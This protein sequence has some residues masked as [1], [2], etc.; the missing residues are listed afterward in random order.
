MTEQENR[1]V[2]VREE[3]DVAT[4]DESMRFIGQ[5]IQTMLSPVVEAMAGFM[6]HNTEAVERLAA[7]QKVQTDRIEA[8]ESKSV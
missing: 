3:N 5:M 8:L 4:D 2:A 6:K 1:E 7:L